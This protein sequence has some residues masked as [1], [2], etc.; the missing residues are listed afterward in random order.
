MNMDN[1][2][3]MSFEESEDYITK[4]G[5][6]IPWNDCDVFVDERDIT[7]TVAN[8][9]KWADYTSTK[10]AIKCLNET[11]YKLTHECKY[12][13]EYNWRELEIDF[14]LKET[15]MERFCKLMEE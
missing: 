2:F 8:V 3:N 7:R 12:W 6:D 9:L 10:K 13:T 1:N 5:F 15:L 14:D 4:R 11:F